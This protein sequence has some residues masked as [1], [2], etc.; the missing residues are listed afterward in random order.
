MSKVTISAGACIANN[1]TALEV[2]ANVTGA[3]RVSSATVT[4]TE[5]KP[6]DGALIVICRTLSTPAMLE[7]IAPN[8]N[9]RPGKTKPPCAAIAAIVP[10]P[11]LK[12]SR[13]ASIAARS[14]CELTTSTDMVTSAVAL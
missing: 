11:V 13:L 4:V 9:L 12:V 14:G 2:T 10:P 5:Y 6:S 1:C 8:F 7:D 3:R